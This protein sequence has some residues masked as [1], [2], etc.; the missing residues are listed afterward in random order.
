MNHYLRFYSVELFNVFAIQTVPSNTFNDHYCNILRVRRLYSSFN[1]E[2]NLLIYIKTK[3]TT[4]INKQIHTCKPDYKF[5]CLYITQHT[6]F[7]YLRTLSLQKY[8][9]SSLYLR[10]VYVKW[11]SGLQLCIGYLQ[12]GGVSLWVDGWFL[13]VWV[14]GSEVY[15][16]LING[17]VKPVSSFTV[18][19]FRIKLTYLLQLSPLL[20]WMMHNFGPAYMLQ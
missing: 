13:P 4:H 19:H 18:Y 17:D 8:Y 10:L 1:I 11:F 14:C 2:D 5:N 9:F 15:S 20:S 7:I 3:V 12:V 16:G 6:V